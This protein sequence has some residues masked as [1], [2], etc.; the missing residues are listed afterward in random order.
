MV[1]GALV[2]VASPPCTSFH[3]PPSVS[4]SVRTTSHTN[5]QR[6]RR[7]SPCLPSLQDMSSVRL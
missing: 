7:S 6:S 2:L 3:H 4:P 1:W 5:T